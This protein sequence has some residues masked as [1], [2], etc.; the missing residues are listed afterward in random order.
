[1]R[2]TKCN[3]TFEAEKEEIN[4]IRIAQQRSQTNLMLKRIL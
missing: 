1:M 3:W 2:C 4:Y